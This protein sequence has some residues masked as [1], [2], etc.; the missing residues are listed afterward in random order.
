MMS[1]EQRSFLKAVVIVLVIVMLGLFFLHGGARWLSLDFV[2]DHRDRLLAYTERHYLGTLAA[3]AAGY[4]VVIALGLP[5]GAVLSLAMGL[6]FGRLVGTVTTV[7]AATAG[8]ILAFSAAR[9]V[10]AD[11]L[12]ARLAARPKAARLIEGFREN[13]F[14]YLLFLRLVPLFPFWL[15]NL[16]PAFTGMDTRT[17]ALATLLGVIPGSFVY[18]NLGQTLGAIGSVRDALSG[19][20]L[21]ALGLLGALALLPVLIKAARP[22][23]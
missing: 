22:S 9:F 16:V 4:V 14:H 3:A 20:T 10:F 2:K 5:G 23:A 18:V 11:A 19:E 13:A 12:C 15:V 7:L 17:Y 6:L 8:A 1:D 21:L